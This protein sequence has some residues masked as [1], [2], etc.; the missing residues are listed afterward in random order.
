MVKRAFFIL[1]L[2]LCMF[3]FLIST[4]VALANELVAHW[5][6]NET[7]GLTV[8]DEK[9]LSNGTL[10][11]L[12]ENAWV[13]GLDGNALDF[14]PNNT[15]GKVDIPDNGFIRV[16]SSQSFSYSVLLSCDFL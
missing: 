15:T 8:A 11:N 1:A 10:V 16:D 6:F 2:S 4:N 9:A 14:G 3:G 5:K 12:G 7:N 13:R